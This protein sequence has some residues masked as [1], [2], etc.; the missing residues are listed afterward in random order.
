MDGYKTPAAGGRSVLVRPCI[1]TPAVQLGIVSTYG[2]II[3][4]VSLDATQLPGLLGTLELASE[5]AARESD[6]AR[7]SQEAAAKESLL[8]RLAAAE[9]QRHATHC[10][11]G[12]ELTSGNT[13]VAGGNRRACR[14]C[15]SEGNYWWK[16]R[17]GVA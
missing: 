6:E 9:K 4:D 16:K 15:R 1:W 3:E 2:N 12:H 7:I 5:E 8:D 13:C 10:P 17:N 11:K 14:R